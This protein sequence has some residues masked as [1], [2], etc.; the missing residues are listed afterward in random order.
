MWGLSS[1]CCVIHRCYTAEQRLMTLLTTKIS[2]AMF[3]LRALVMVQCRV[4]GPYQRGLSAQQQVALESLKTF[5]T[6]SSSLNLYFFIIFKVG[7]FSSSS[8]SILFL[9]STKSIFFFVIFKVDTFSTCSK[10][11]LC[12]TYSKLILFQFSIFKDD[13]F[14]SSSKSILFHYL[15]S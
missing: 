4:R 1:Y 12:L 5:D 7:T 8:K 14:S 3:V 10:L 6:F 13:T 15:Q 9:S 2:A 11:L